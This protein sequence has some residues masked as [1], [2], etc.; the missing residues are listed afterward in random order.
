MPVEQT[1]KFIEQFNRLHA[2]ALEPFAVH[3]RHHKKRVGKSAVRIMTSI[4]A[5]PNKAA[6]ERSF[7]N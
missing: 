7:P 5:L 1:P 3:A 2:A 6:E 4:S